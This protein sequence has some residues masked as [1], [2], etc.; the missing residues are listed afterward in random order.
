MLPWNRIQ[1]LLLD[2]D[3]TLLDLHFDNHFWLEHVP[4][5]YAE[6]HGLALS[7]AKTRLYPRFRAMEGTMQWYC[8]NYWTEQLDLDIAEL[9]REIRELIAIHPH[10]TDFLD[11]ARAHDKQIVLVTNAHHM[12]LQLKLEETGLGGHFDRQICSHDF[13]SPKEDRRFWGWLKGQVPY[14]EAST[15]LIDD[16]LPVLRSARDYGIGHL[17][18]VKRPDARGPA[19][20]TGEFAAIDS[21][22]DLIRSLRFGVRSEE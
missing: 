12:A 22:D 5:R 3:G 13:G 7:D 9:K 16:S 8:V 19:R 17:L 2:M 21:F 10:V 6:R 1:T 18:A 4:L 20:D 11:L 15:L 14:E